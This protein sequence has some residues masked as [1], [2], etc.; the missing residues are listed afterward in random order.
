MR[1]L[2]KLLLGVFCAGVLLTGIG[3]G[4]LFTEFTSLTYGG[5]QILGETDM[6]TENVDVEFEPEERKI[7]ITG[8]YGWEQ[9]DILT[10]ARVPENTVRFCVTYNG[11]RVVP[12]A[13]WEKGNQEEYSQVWLSRRW[14]AE[15]DEMELMMEAKDMFLE[16]LKA[17]RIISFDTVQVES[18][19]VT[20]NPL[21]IEDVQLVY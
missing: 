11:K 9:T 17:G 7:L 10:D 15:E 16:N 2:H 14:I 12:V 20:V 5:K 18:V 8:W 19:T 6:R 4:I 21:N 13:V 1:K 3:A